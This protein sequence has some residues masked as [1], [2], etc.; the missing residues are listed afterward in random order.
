MSGGKVRT[1]EIVIGLNVSHSETATGPLSTRN[2]LTV[3]IRAQPS[4]AGPGAR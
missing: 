4:G 1:S 2:Y 3:G